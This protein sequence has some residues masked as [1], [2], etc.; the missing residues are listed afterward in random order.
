MICSQCGD[1]LV[2]DRFMDW[3][4]R[5]RCLKCGHG[6]D[7]DTV[8]P[9]LARQE[10]DLFSKHIEICREREQASLVEKEVW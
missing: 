9:Y 8:Q 5:R 10:N 1:L 7:S 6:Q 3:T 2:E 4:A